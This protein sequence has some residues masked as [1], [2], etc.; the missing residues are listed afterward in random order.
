MIRKI[1]KFLAG[2]G[3]IL[4]FTHILNYA[5]NSTFAHRKR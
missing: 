3:K 2:K 4:I 1:L 5:Q